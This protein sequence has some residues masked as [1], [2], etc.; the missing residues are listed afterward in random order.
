MKTDLNKILIT[1]VLDNIPK[2]IKPVSYLMDALQLSR[3]SVYRRIRGEIPFSIEETALLSIK[4]GFSAD[5]ILGGSKKG[6]AFFDL[7]SIK[8]AESS[9]AFLVMLRKYYEHI[10]GV[11]NA[12]DGRSI[13]ALNRLPP[14][15]H[16]FFDN[17]FRFIYYKWLHQN[18]EITSKQ[19]FLNV[20]IP[21]ELALLQEKIQGGL[22]RISNISLIFDPNVFLSIIRDIQYFYQRKLVSSEELDL[23]KEDMF[24]LIDFYEEIAKT[25]MLD[26]SSKINIYLSPL[27]INANTCYMSLD[28]NTSES[29]FWILTVNPMF[30]NNPEVCTMHKKWLSSLQRQSILITLSN[31]ILQTEFF[32][33]QRKYIDK[34]LGESISVIL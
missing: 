3:E 13:M 11:I 30:V 10:E 9:E 12:E 17:L 27:Y 16:V 31:E 34:Y 20:A 15:F 19:H 14:A 8:T 22:R 24:K 18:D 2:S 1:T 25:G 21:P 28:Q 6:R 4:L 26:F 33:K 23:L 5:E 29:I 7:L 32:D